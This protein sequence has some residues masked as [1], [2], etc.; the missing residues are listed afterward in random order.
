MPG[1]QT[2]ARLL[3]LAAPMF[4]RLSLASVLPSKET[5]CV[6]QKRGTKLPN[7]K[8]HWQGQDSD[9]RPLGYEATRLAQP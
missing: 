7:W 8:R 3:F 6:T 9:L 1:G 2:A 4:S 5:G